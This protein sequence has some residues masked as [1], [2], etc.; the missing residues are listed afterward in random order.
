MDKKKRLIAQI[1]VV[2]VI[3]ALVLT[4]VLWAVQLSV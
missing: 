2:A 1:V 4:T 3:A